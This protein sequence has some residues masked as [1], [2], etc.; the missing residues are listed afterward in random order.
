MFDLAF[1]LY[2]NC[3]SIGEKRQFCFSESESTLHFRFWGGFLYL[4]RGTQ[5]SLE[6]L[7]GNYN[8]TQP[9]LETPT[10]RHFCQFIS[11]VPALSPPKLTQLCPPPWSGAQWQT[12]KIT[13]ITKISLLHYQHCSGHKSK[14]W[15]CMGSQRK[16]CVLP[17]WWTQPCDLHSFFDNILLKAH[18]KG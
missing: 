18:K 16:S 11:A 5:N 17:L 8:I 4:D 2:L 10:W 12:L 1:I 6:G 13:I 7:P 9:A 3:Y 14:P 15:H